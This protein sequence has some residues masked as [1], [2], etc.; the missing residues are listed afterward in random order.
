MNEPFD[1]YQTPLDACSLESLQ[2]PIKTA[3]GSVWPIISSCYSLEK[4]G[5]R[6]GHMDLFLVK[7]PLKEDDSIKFEKPFLSFSFPSGI[8]DGKFFPKNS[9]SHTWWYA[10]AHSTGDIKLHTLTLNDDSR[11]PIFACQASFSS[12]ISGKTG[13]PVLCLAINWDTTRG[14]DNARVVSSYS[15]GKIAIH[16]VTLSENGNPELIECDCWLGHTIFG[17]NPA[18][19][20]ACA[21]AAEGKIVVTGGDDAIVKFWDSRALS[22]PVQIMRDCFQ[23]GVTVISPHPRNPNV[24]A[25]GSYDETFGIF[26]IR[27][28]SQKL[29]C[30]SEKMGGGIWR[31]QWHPESDDKLLLAV[32]HGGCRVVQLEPDDDFNQI[33]KIIKEFTKHKSMAYG[34]DW[35]VN[36]SIETAASCSF[37]DQ[38]AYIWDTK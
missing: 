29:L 10:T 25:I 3:D 11:D 4:D 35:L 2:K 37:Y 16:D 6:A 7:V 31:I 18:E 32:M 38:A 21:F 24:V 30:K 12:P 33:P 23:A 1:H 5:S 26:D 27:Y 17:D 34:V 22:R 14:F 20:W 8:L 9:T 15:N 19:V 36:D 28:N 13:V